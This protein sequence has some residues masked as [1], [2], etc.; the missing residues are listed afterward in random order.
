M[1]NNSNKVVKAGLGYTIGNI[2]HGKSE[3][4]MEEL[5][6]YCDNERLETKEMR[7]IGF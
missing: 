7:K 5:S 1:S 3:N 4:I 6:S 2:L